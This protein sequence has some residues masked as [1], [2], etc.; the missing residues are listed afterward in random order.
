MDVKEFRYPRSAL[1]P[2]YGRAAAGVAVS[3]AVLL[4]A[5]P[6]SAMLWVAGPVLLLFAAFGCVTA[7]KQATAIRLDAEGVRCIG[8][9]VRTIRWNELQRVD[10]RYYSTK[11]D[12]SDGWMQLTIRGKGSSIRIESTIEGFSD[13]V[14]AAAGAA[15]RQGLAISEASQANMEAL[16]LR[17]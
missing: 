7:L 13:L 4:F 11:K 12:R 1:I 17:R 16:G 8:P 6:S 15:A 3:G 9:L 10:L 2:H 5:G 14:A